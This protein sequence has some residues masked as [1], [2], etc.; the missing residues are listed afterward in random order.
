MMTGEDLGTALTG[1]WSSCLKIAEYCRLSSVSLGS[2][3]VA[4]NLWRAEALQIF[5]GLRIGER[6]LRLSACETFKSIND[7]K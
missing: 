5:S 3:I 7:A 2:K 6:T 4:R 1:S